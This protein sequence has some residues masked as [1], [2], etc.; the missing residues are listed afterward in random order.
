MAARARENCRAFPAVRVENVSFEDWPL[1]R[2]A[3][4]LVVSASAFHWIAPE[5]KFA[6]TAAALR[7]GGS[8]ALFWNRF[9]G[10]PTLLREALD[11]IYR[12]E[13]PELGRDKPE[14]LETVIR[15]PRDELDASGLFDEVAVRRYPWSERYTAEQYGK[16]VQTY[17]D[18]IALPAD[19]RERL[20]R[21]VEELIQELGGTIDRPYV[22]V[23]YVARCR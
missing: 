1:E 21:R 13:A 2:A 3:F 9:P 20:T 4:D 17:S 5:A 12:E 18:H 19:A 15:R 23:L 10:F 22:S 6:K 8:L 14:D 16:L 11:R 7:S